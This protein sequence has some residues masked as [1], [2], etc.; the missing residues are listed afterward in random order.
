MDD[1]LTKQ[2]IQMVRDV[3]RTFALSIEQLPKPL[4]AATGIAYLLL[5]V[6]DSLEDDPDL[7]VER[8]LS[9]L[10][11]W[12]GVLD[13]SEP[14]SRLTR[15]V[16][17][18]DSNNPDVRVIQNADYVLEQL[19][20]LPAEIGEP[21]TARVHKTTLGMARW[22]EHGPYVKDEAA[23]DDYMHEVAGRVGYL[24]TDLFSWYS[25]AVRENKAELMPLSRHCGLALQTVN[26]IRGMRKDY[27]RG[28]VF[29]PQ[30]FLEK[31]GLT[32]DSL[33]DRVNLD[34][35]MG[36]VDMLADKADRHLE[37]GLSYVT[38]L[39][40]RQHSLRLA[41]MWPFFFAVRTLAVSRK[42]PQVLLNEAKIRRDEVGRILMETRLLGWSNRWLER[43]YHRLTRPPADVDEGNQP[44]MPDL[45]QGREAVTDSRSRR[46][47]P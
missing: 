11:T 42:N 37:Y 44:A 31:Q 10:G 20:A 47:S 36:V 21:I 43:F 12:A 26:V 2:H 1:I 6:S 9:L 24:V 13:G 18:L 15:A 28:W 25:P 40:R 19:H 33:F 34:R 7:S 22:Q 8:K 46:G 16:V 29:A 23:L 35:A 27:E 45:R 41:L 4:R 14:V 39:P 5:R 38:T 32:R 30:S 3:S 17:D